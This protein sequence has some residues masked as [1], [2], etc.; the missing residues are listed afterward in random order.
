M[1]SCVLQKVAKD[2][3]KSR[4]E[5]ESRVHCKDASS[6]PVSNYNKYGCTSEVHKMDGA[7]QLRASTVANGRP[8]SRPNSLELQ[9]GMVLPAAAPAALTESSILSANALSSVSPPAPPVRTVISSATSD[10]SADLLA[11]CSSVSSAKSDKAKAPDVTGVAAASNSAT[12]DETGAAPAGVSSIQLNRFAAESTSKS[13]KHAAEESKPQESNRNNCNSTVLPS[14]PPTP[15]TALK[16][17]IVESTAAVPSPARSCKSEGRGGGEGTKS[18]TPE[19]VV[20]LPP[21][22]PTPP[23]QF[24]QTGSLDSPG[25][26]LP[27][28]PLDDEEC[29]DVIPQ[30]VSPPP[31]MSPP[32]EDLAVFNARNEGCSAEQVQALEPASGV[33]DGVSIASDVSSA[34]VSSGS[35]GKSDGVAASA[36]TDQ[37]LVRD[38]RSDLLAAIREGIVNFPVLH[39]SVHMIFMTTRF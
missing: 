20:D 26:L 29:F 9:N 19:S 25:T 8:Q 34:T 30:G 37:P 39:A 35:T 18:S 27:P 32:P 5:I 3:H 11:T 16:Q 6:R 28:P 24:C 4:S 22:P 31:P 17:R 2:A 23:P 12:I 1:M 36:T 10:I 38:T 13:P 21:P 14:P 7:V 15:P 33:V